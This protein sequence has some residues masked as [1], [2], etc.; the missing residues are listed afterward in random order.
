MSVVGTDES[1]TR[2]CY[3]TISPY[4]SEGDIPGFEGYIMFVSGVYLKD[5]TF[6]EKRLSYSL[7]RKMYSVLCTE[8]S[9]LP[10]STDAV[11][12]E[13]NV[14]NER[15]FLIC[16]KH[17][18]YVDIE[19]ESYQMMVT[20]SVPSII[21]QVIKDLVVWHA[22]VIRALDSE[23][24][25]ITASSLFTTPRCI[26]DIFKATHYNVTS[27]HDY[28]ISGIVSMRCIRAFAG[29]PSQLLPL[30]ANK[31]YSYYHLH[32]WSMTQ[33]IIHSCEHFI[34][35]YYYYRHV[36]SGNSP[37]H[38]MQ[39]SIDIVEELALNYMSE[40]NAAKFRSKVSDYRKTFGM[41][42]LDSSLNQYP[43][44]YYNNDNNV[45]TQ[46]LGRRGIPY[47]NL[48]DYQYPRISDR[49]VPEEL[50]TTD[51]YLSIFSTVWN[52]GMNV[53]N[54][55]LKSLKHAPKRNPVRID[56]DSKDMS[57]DFDSIFDNGEDFKYEREEL[58]RIKQDKKSFIN[59]TITDFIPE[60][61]KRKDN[62]NNKR[63]K[64]NT[65]RNGRR[66]PNYKKSNAPTFTYFGVED[67]KK[68]KDEVKSRKI[69]NGVLSKTNP[70]KNSKNKRN[71][72]SKIKIPDDERAA[73]VRLLSSLDS[74][75][76]LQIHTN[77]NAKLNTFY[78]IFSQNGGLKDIESV[79]SQL[80]N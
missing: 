9:L 80:P 36:L 65:K 4:R 26:Y 73:Y 27:V 12:Y 32:F 47:C 17:D 51:N 45:L 16:T 49:E 38:G 31:E 33:A 10:N 6:I 48:G 3:S 34:P 13:H 72:D 58:E 64:K 60:M 2:Y 56:D 14:D 69:E 21:A 43:V 1:Y 18:P 44:T 41:R 30:F 57:I 77:T 25:V 61:V 40:S 15:H 11:I 70:R 75:G 74:N 7:I 22:R 71:N 50:L 63:A 37:I 19:I 55:L 67:E 42:S 52:P 23:D 62:G 59:H 68:S 39:A 8:H 66:S 28:I 78:E 53:P 5:G 35:E 79:K 20:V 54:V 76:L 46:M 24:K 29:L